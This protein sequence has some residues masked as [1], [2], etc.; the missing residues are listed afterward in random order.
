MY[1]ST[2]VSLFPLATNQLSV[3]LRNNA[4]LT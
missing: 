4:W 2:K 1:R 3:L